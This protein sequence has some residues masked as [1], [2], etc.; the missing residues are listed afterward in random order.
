MLLGATVAL[1]VMTGL[2]LMDAQ[3]ALGQPDIPDALTVLP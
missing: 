2:E 1:A 3:Q